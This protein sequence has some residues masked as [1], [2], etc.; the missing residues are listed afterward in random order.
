MIHPHTSV[1]MHPPPTHL[2][3]PPPSHHPPPLPPP[4]H[5]PPP[6]RHPSPPQHLPPPLHSSPHHP[7][8][9]EKPAVQTFD[10]GHGNGHVAPAPQTFEHNHGIGTIKSES[11][12]SDSP[13]H[14]YDYGNNQQPPANRDKRQESTKH[15]EPYHHFP[16]S[17]PHPH[18]NEMYHQE[19][20][21]CFNERFKI[22][23]FTNFTCLSNFTGG[24]GGGGGVLDDVALCI[25]YSIKVKA[26]RFRLFQDS[27]IGNLA[28]TRVLVNN[29]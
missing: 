7:P 25:D 2:L 16:P 15:S 5:P 26:V 11:T 17:L 18:H 20:V 22:S 28:D 21:K 4:R 23:Q 9:E 8:P 6:Q 27:E 3:P 10:Y 19:E 14:S 1:P 24:G 29:L 13:S 12:H